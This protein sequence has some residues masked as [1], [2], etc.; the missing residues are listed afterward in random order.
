MKKTQL[1]VALVLTLLMVLA[2]APGGLSLAA[3]PLAPLPAP[4]QKVYDRSDK[5]VLEGKPGAS[6]VW[7]PRVQDSTEDYVESPGGKRQVYYFEKG[8]LEI[9]NPAKDPNDKYYVTSGLLLREMITG[10]FQ[11]GDSQVVDHGP[12]NV[13]LAG[14]IA[15]G[16]PDSPTYASLTNLVSFDGSWRS[17]DVTGQPVDKLLGLGGAISTRPDLVQGVTYGQYYKETGHNVAK[18]F[19]DFMNHTG[20]IYENGKYVNNVQVF[21]P[22]YVFGYP[23]S[24]PYWTHVTVAGKEQYVLVQAFE[25]RLLT[26]TPSNP[27]P[28]KV[29]LGNLG[30]AYVK[31][32]YNTDAT[33]FNNTD[34]VPARPQATDGFNLY[35]GINNNMR[36]LNFVK[37]NISINGKVYSQQQFQAPDRARALQNYTYQGKPAQVETIVIGTRWYIRL[38]QGNQSS[39]WLYGDNQIPDIWP[40]GFPTTLPITFP[41][42]FPVFSLNDWSIDWQAGPQQAVG[43]DVRRTLTAGLTDLDGS[44]VTVARLVSEKN[45]VVIS[46]AEQDILPDNGQTLTQSSDYADYNVPISLNPPAGAVPAS[47]SSSIDMNALYLDLPSTGNAKADAAIQTKLGRQGAAVANNRISSVIVKF[48]DTVGA[49]SFGFGGEL[50][51]LSLDRNFNFQ[52]STTP[53]VFKLNGQPLN[54]TLAQLKADPRVEYAEPNSIVYSS[55]TTFSDPQFGDQYYLNTIK[56]PRAWDFTHGQKGVTVAVIDSGVDL[57]NPDLQGQIA[58]TYNSNK[59]GTDVTDDA[60]H[61]SW[62]TG[63][64]GAI[65]NNNV[66]GTGLAWNTKIIHIKADLDDQPGAFTK[67]SIVAAIHLAVDKGARVIN[68]SLG[69]PSSSQAEVDAINYALSHNVVVVAASGNSGDNEKEYPS[70]YPGVISVGA[71]GY[72]DQPTYFS[73]FNGNVIL[74]APGLHIC[75]TGRAQVFACAN[76]TS[77]S[78]PI[79]AGAAAMILSANSDLTADQVKAILIAS[80]SPAPGKQVGQRDDHY[81]Y[82]ILNVAK[83]LQ[84][85]STNQVP[86]LPADLP[87]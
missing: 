33:V 15:P 54:Q 49:Q 39:D 44:K 43:T 1:T 2:L 22:L 18:P 13:P 36:G 9:N 63:I 25:R 78:S 32:R 60:G 3:D 37:R 76:G 29:E 42:V 27:D 47:L 21:D 6:W 59:G 28:Y 80:A 77:A 41:S 10:Q 75:N 83:A 61:G 67:S 11:V 46:S 17:D 69:G 8:R 85:A 34:P 52:S 38:L 57:K 64:I 51:A 53:V 72:Y 14:D 74:S 56:A 5:A 7:G 45:G 65:G 35:N 62:T 81:G 12:A 66:Y 84:M 4:V 16:V 19:V 40:L 71:T 31:W 26:Y 73:T 48:K 24:E 50:G 87:R 79:V 86:V 82:G 70:S 68:M 58:E 30:L 20:T 23:I 55:I